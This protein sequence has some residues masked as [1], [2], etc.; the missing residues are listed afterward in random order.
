MM[1]QR[2]LSQHTH[3]QQSA[4]AAHFSAPCGCRA[5]SKF[6]S[7]GPCSRLS[8]LL[9][10]P[11]RQAT[12][13]AGDL[14][15]A[16]KATEAAQAA[17]KAAEDANGQCQLDLTAANDAKKAAEDANGQCQLDKTAVCGGDSSSC[18]TGGRR[19]AFKRLF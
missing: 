1:S 6:E 13:C 2:L 17:Q 18:P 15:D 16:N 8:P 12:K 5:C 11:S 3:Q 9:V 14:A 4:A 19:L 10:C 7:T